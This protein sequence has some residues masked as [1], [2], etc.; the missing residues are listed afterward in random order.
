M[1]EPQSDQRSKPV[2]GTAENLLQVEDLRVSFPGPLGPVEIVCGLSFDL[3]KATITGLV[4][5]RAVERV[6]PPWH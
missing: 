6:S 1:G 5:N 4:G 2:E 3:P